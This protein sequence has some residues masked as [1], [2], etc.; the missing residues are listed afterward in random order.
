MPTDEAVTPLPMP[1][2]TPPVTITYLVP[3]GRLISDSTR[4]RGVSCMSIAEDTRS[5]AKLTSYT[6]PPTRRARADPVP[7]AYA[8][9]IFGDTAAVVSPKVHSSSTVVAESPRSSRRESKNFSSGSE[10]AYAYMRGLSSRELCTF[11]STCSRSFFT[12]TLPECMHVPFMEGLPLLFPFVVTLD[13]SSTPPAQ[14][15]SRTRE[16]TQ[17]TMA[18]RFFPRPNFL[19]RDRAG[20]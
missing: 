18:R 7:H 15:W 8:C 10:R 6:H 20:G 19:P 11:T 12:C 4:L 13:M 14:D 2:T 16:G 1:D 5:P 3:R 17:G 9:T